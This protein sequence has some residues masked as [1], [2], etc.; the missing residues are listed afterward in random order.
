MIVHGTY[1]V[2]LGLYPRRSFVS[3]LTSKVTKAALFSR[4][5]LNEVTGLA[6]VKG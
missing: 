3:R 6:R 5:C 2:F 4:A 1:L